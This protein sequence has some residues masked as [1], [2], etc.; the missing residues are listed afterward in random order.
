MKYVQ[1][2]G[3]IWRMSE[4]KFKQLTHK[5]KHNPGQSV[6]LDNYGKLIITDPISLEDMI[7][8]ATE[9]DVT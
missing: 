4:R 1:W 2:M 3:G 8:E 9:E 5:L 7:T 6:D